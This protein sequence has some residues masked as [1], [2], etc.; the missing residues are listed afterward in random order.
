MKQ[1]LNFQFW[2]DECVVYDKL[3]G[4]SFL[5]SLTNGELL[6]LIIEDSP[7]VEFIIKIKEHM[8]LNKDEAKEYLLNVMGEFSKLGLIVSYRK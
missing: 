1:E 8:H 6:K 2:Q 7:E 4:N 3:S 5:L